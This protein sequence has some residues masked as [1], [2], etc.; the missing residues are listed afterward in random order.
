MRAEVVDDSGRKLPPVSQR[1]AI[2]FVT[3]YAIRKNHIS[4]FDIF[5]FLVMTKTQAEVVDDSGQ[6]IPKVP[7]KDDKIVQWFWQRH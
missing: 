5:T 2:V 6:E 1:V 3:V 4:N 7:P